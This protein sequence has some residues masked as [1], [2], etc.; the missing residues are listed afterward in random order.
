MRGILRSCDDLMATGADLEVWC[1]NHDDVKGVKFRRVP[2]I[3]APAIFMG[4]AFFL[5]VH[6]FWIS[7]ILMGNKR[8]GD[9][10]I[11][12]GFYLLPADA[13]FVHFSHFDWMQAQ[14]RIGFKTLRDWL[15]LGYSLMCRVPAELLLLWNPWPT[16]LVVVSK[17]VG[18]DMK[19]WGA[20][21][22]KQKLLPNPY[23]PELFNE[24]VRLQNRAK[25][26]SSL[27]I[28]LH[29]TVFVFA[30]AGHYQRKGFWLAA[31]TVS[32]LVKKHP[33]VHLLVIGGSPCAVAG[34]RRT[35]TERFGDWSSWLHF[36]GMTGEMPRLLSA[37]DAL[38]FPSYSEAF[39]LVEIEAA[40]L[41]LRLYLTPHHGSEMILNESVNG[42]SIPWDIPG[43]T[44]VLDEEI[45]RR[46]VMPGVASHGLAP[47]QA[48]YASRLLVA[49]GVDV[50]ACGPTKNQGHDK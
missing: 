2:R 32:Q 5:M 41:G 10:L 19:R 29:D 28:G 37:G 13:S 45:R 16:R 30:S 47:A 15:E 36:T 25:A 44:S 21:W 18:E 11:S 39:A 8:Q 24:T 43:I 6:L 4:W 23:D 14:F 48:E 33:G 26:R 17:S 49:L 27:G 20:P 50:E 3:P 35:A 38:L 9:L 46:A 40:S 31:E 12:T 22:K 42:R 34:L 7:W 1:W